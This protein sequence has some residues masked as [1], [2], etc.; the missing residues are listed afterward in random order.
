MSKKATERPCVNRLIKAVQKNSPPFYVHVDRDSGTRRHTSS[1]WDFLL[2]Y[3]CRASF[4]EA[5]MEDGALSDW[6]QYTRAAVT[7]T[8]G[9]YNVVRFWDN[10]EFYTVNDGSMIK[11]DDAEIGDFL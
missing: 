9:T 5:K 6:Q 4:N 11:I 1:G 8:G 2:S 3:Y 7:S 10:G